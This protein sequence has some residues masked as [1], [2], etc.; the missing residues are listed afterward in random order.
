MAETKTE[1][2]I[3]EEKKVATPVSGTITPVLRPGETAVKHPELTVLAR[4]EGGFRRAD[5]FF[6][7]T[8]EVI[9]PANTLSQRALDLITE[10]KGKKLAVSGLK[11]AEKTETK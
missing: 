3:K 8:E 10:E 4:P 11:K 5:I 1:L 9:I 2:G 6:S 7:G